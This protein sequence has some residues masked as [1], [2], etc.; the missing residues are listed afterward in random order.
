MKDNVSIDMHPLAANCDV[1]VRLRALFPEFTWD[2]RAAP[3]PACLLGRDSEG[4]EIQAWYGQRPITLIISYYKAWQNQG[5]REIRKLAS[6]ADVQQRC[7][8]GFRFARV[9]M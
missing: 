7:A 2:D 8:E 9:I 4:V 3:Q 5:D 6:I 1:T